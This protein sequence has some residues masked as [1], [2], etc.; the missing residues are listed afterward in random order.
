MLKIKPVILRMLTQTAEVPFS[1][2]FA[3]SSL[4][5]SLFLL[6]YTIA[7]PTITLVDSGTMPRAFQT[8]PPAGGSCAGSRIT[9]SSLKPI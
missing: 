4:S 6:L 7:M 9:Y 2:R 8:T 5:S 3:L 1:C